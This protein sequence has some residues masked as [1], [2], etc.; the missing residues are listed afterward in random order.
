[1]IQISSFKSLVG[2]KLGG[3][4]VS[5]MASFYSTLYEAMIKVKNNVDLPS[6]IR[7]TQLTN[8]VYNDISRYIV[9]NDLGMQGIINL[10]PII[11]DDSFY[12]YSNFSQ[13]QFTVENKYSTGEFTK[14]YAIRYQDGV[15]YLNISGT[16]TAP[17]VISDCES[18]TSNGT[19]GVYG[20]SSDIAADSLQVYAGSSSLGFTI[21]TG[22]A[23]GIE[24]STLTSV[25]LSSENDIFFA[26]YIATLTGF[27]GVRLS[28]G[29]ST[30]AYY[31]GTATSDFF[32]N[33]IKV[34]WNLIKISRSSFSVGVGAPS[35]DG[36]TFARLEI[37]GT[38]VASTSGFRLDNLV[39]N[40]GVLMEI[41]YYSDFSFAS[42]SMSFKDMP[43]DDSDYIVMDGTE[44]PMLIN[45]FIEIAALDLKQSG[46]GTDYNGYGGKVLK[47]MYDEFKIQYPSQRQL[48]ITKYSNRPRFDL[49]DQGLRGQ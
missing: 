35:W 48:M 29:Q 40:V 41:D 39:A 7:T 20:V 16:G 14:R 11:N 8:P 37:L 45:Q 12:D 25:D 1:M 17:T 23:Q 24:N 27:T 47:D 13:R 43:T 34:G 5:K 2:N 9:P 46:A 30:G 31:Q 44:L 36:V 21:N 28:L 26:V 49:P 4:P 6:S 42:S 3:K 10:R 32:G 38:F 18:L 15:P 22:G 33:T 19:W